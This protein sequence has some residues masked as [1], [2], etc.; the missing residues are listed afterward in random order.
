MQT[1]KLAASQ[2]KWAEESIR[3]E[4][5]FFPQNKKDRLLLFCLC[6]AKLACMQM[7]MPSQAFLAYILKSLQYNED[8]G[9][10]FFQEWIER[11]FCWLKLIPSGPHVKWPTHSKAFFGNNLKQ[12]RNPRFR[13][14]NPKHSFEKNGWCVTCNNISNNLIFPK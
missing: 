3:F 5:L 6:F 10:C 14:Y 7:Q 13:Q 12:W 8:N 4:N 11:I 1:G 9:N 2:V